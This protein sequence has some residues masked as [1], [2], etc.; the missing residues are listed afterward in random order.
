M[1]PVMRSTEDAPDVITK[2]PFAGLMDPVCCL[3]DIPIIHLQFHSGRYGE[4]AVGFHRESVV[5]AGFTPVFYQ[6]QDSD[7]ARAIVNVIDGFD[8]LGS[9]EPKADPP[10]EREKREKPSET[11]GEYTGRITLL[12]KTLRGSL[13]YWP[14]KVDPN[15]AM[16][17][18]DRALKQREESKESIM[19]FLK[20]LSNL[21]I[22][23]DW[24]RRTSI[25][26]RAPCRWSCVFRIMGKNP[27]A[28]K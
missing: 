23:G 2:R 15:R 14:S 8:I 22:G 9:F 21:G 25:V 10:P 20:G 13:W 28:A 6:L 26:Y 3:A 16:G 5:N 4:M 27:S 11:K 24:A 1:R 19:A 18:L 7:L 12:P 17:R